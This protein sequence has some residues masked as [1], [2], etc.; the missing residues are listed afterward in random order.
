MTRGTAVL[1]TSV[2]LASNRTW[3]TA[4]LAVFELRHKMQNHPLLRG[5]KAKKKIPVPVWNLC[6]EGWRRERAVQET[7]KEALAFTEEFRVSLN[8]KQGG[9]GLMTEF[10]I[11][12]T[13]TKEGRAGVP[14][15]LE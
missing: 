4:R 12:G 14:E 10:R 8:Q 1:L 13:R 2:P 15:A 7:S 11:T 3:H 5:S 9:L 6:A